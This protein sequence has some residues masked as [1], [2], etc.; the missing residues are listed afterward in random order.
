[1]PTVVRV[2][3]RQQLTFFVVVIVGDMTVRIGRFG[4][5]TLGVA[6]IFPHGFA[7]KPCVQETVAILVGRRFVFR[8]NQRDKP[9]DLVVTVF[10]DG[11]ERILLGNQP[12]VVVVG[13]EVFATVQ[14]DLAHQSRPVVVDVNLF[15]AIDVLDGDTALVIPDVTRVHLRKRRPMADTSGSLAGPFPLPE[16][17]RPTGQLP[18]QDDVLIVVVVALAFAGGVGGFDQLIAFVVAVAD[19]RLLGVPGLVEGVG[20]M[21]TLIVDGDQMAAVIAQQQGAA[22]AIVEAF[23]AVLSIAGDAQAVVVSV[24]DGRQPTV[25]KVIEPRVVTRLGEDQFFGF[26]AEINRRPREAVVDRRAFTVWQ[27]K[28][29][30]TVFVVDPDDGVAIDFQS[31]GEAVT[32]AET[33]AAVDLGGA[34]AIEPGEVERQDA[35]QRTV[36]EGQQFFAGD[37]R[38]RAFVGGGFINGIGAVAVGVFRLHSRRR[39]GVRLCLSVVLRRAHPSAAASGLFSCRQRCLA[40]RLFCSGRRS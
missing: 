5:V 6:L 38:H 33:E 36:G 7:A 27:R 16:E 30:A 13:L 20:R 37:H 14:L 1:M 4:D 3:D 40:R 2:T 32:P 24:A 12:T 23:D 19:Q 34:G 28:R 26:I 22:G 29:G 10:G 31:M 8:R 39:R 15:T 18:L 21:K 35:V 17:T 9:S 11:A 25:M